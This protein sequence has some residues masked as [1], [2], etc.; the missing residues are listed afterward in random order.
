MTTGGQVLTFP[1]PVPAELAAAQGKSRAQAISEFIAERFGDVSPEE[2]TDACTRV[3]AAICSTYVDT[4]A[5]AIAL[6][7]SIRNDM[8]A[9]IV[10]MRSDEP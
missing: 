10:E 1:R 2:C 9:L 7:H 3:L 4:T 5:E 8:E 6:S